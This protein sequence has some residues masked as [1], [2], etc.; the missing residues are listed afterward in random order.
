MGTGNRFGCPVNTE[1]FLSDE[2]RLMCYVDDPLAALSGTPER[3]R[4]LAATIILVWSVLGFDLAF[5]K[6][7]LGKT[8]TWIGGTLQCEPWGVKATVKEAI[9]ADI[10]DALKRC[11]LYKS[12][13]AHE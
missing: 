6:G 2:V 5:A 10:C 12:D 4:L 1:L 11:H 8:V 3:R 7:Q 9:V 13:A